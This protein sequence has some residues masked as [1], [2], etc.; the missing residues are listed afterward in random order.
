[1]LARATLRAMRR[2]LAAAVLSVAVLAASRASA[3]GCTL[4]YQGGPLISYPRVVQV[5]WT[6]GVSSSVTSYLPGFF[7][8][9]TDSTYLDWLSEYDVQGQFIN[10]GR[11]DGAYTITP[12]I[13]GMTVTSDQ[14]GAELA[15]QVLAG[16]L[17]A[18]TV[19]RDGRPNTIYS[20]DFPSGYVLDLQGSH[21]CV[22][23][24]AFIGRTT[25]GTTP[26]A[27]MAFPDLGSSSA[28]SGGCGM[29]TLND[30]LGLQHAGQ[31]LNAI[32]DDGAAGPSAAI[33]WYANPNGCGQIADICNQQEAM[34][35]GYTVSKGWS[36]SQNA[37]VVS[38]PTRAPCVGKV[39]DSSCRVC[40]PSDDGVNCTGA[41]PS[42]DN[43]PDS[44]TYGE[45]V[46]VPDAGTGGGAG[47]GGAGG[48]SAAGGGTATGGSAAG[49]SATGGS[50]AGGSAA[51]GSAAGGG[52]AGACVPG[53]QV[54]CACPGGTSGAQAC[55]AAGNG[56]GECQC[57]PAKSGC[58]CGGAGTAEAMMG[59]ALLMLLTR[60]RRA[61]AVYP[62][63]VSRGAS[64]HMPSRS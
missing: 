18:P 57:T 9:I 54:S 11:Y 59:C 22:V 39:P 26:A 5:Y 28:C 53:Q 38:G 56:Y 13:S 30:V 50:A 7:S 12:S 46:A 6:S 2:A 43:N 16:H 61:R 55:N 37:C 40:S 34:V 51:G 42:C 41:T 21:S 63:T 3:A 15:A 52:T 8:A 60:R 35:A 23:F 44:G 4:T 25:I 48:G 29:G 24:C 10:R 1:M 14:I 33:G 20:V 49:G 19:D 62:S 17:P 36:N 58:G 32:T 27:F 31:L 47:G 45:C 64:A